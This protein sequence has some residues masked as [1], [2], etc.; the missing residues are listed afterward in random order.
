MSDRKRKRVDSVSSLSSSD[1]E[2][3]SVLPPKSVNILAELER[4]WIY[5]N[6]SERVRLNEPWHIEGIL[7]YRDT[8]VKHV[9]ERLKD[10]YDVCYRLI[11]RYDMFLFENGI[12]NAKLSVND[13]IGQKIKEVVIKSLEY[14]D[15][16]QRPIFTDNKHYTEL[17]DT[18]HREI[19]QCCDSTKFRFILFKLGLCLNKVKKDHATNKF[20]IYDRNCHANII[21]IDKNKNII[22]RFDPHGN[23]KNTFQKQVN[24]DL[25]DSIMKDVIKCKDITNY[26]F[27]DI[28]LQWNEQIEEN[29]ISGYCNP[30][31]MLYFQRRVEYPN[32]TPDEIGI[33]INSDIN[34]KF[35]EIYYSDLNS[36][37][38]QCE[39]ILI[40][41]K[42]TID[43]YQRVIKGKQ[44]NECKQQ[45]E[46][47][48]HQKLSEFRLDYIRRY[49]ASTHSPF[50]LD[51]RRQLF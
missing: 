3:L 34:S 20:K 29:E 19:R 13:L 30:W 49:V 7:P 26:K 14:D 44:Y 32:K 2:N 22:E 6:P 48:K 51:C 41:Y 45:Y 47:Y 8:Y 37:K 24:F 21:L 46:L 33:L 27:L 23:R 16:S 42:K 9:V 31:C 12:W 50:K 5:D 17:A 35:K 1:D 18:V 25:I 10:R 4:A 11:F 39:V 36:R 15:G 40:D 28:H 38:K 43:P